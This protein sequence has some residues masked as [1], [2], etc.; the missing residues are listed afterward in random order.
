MR[1]RSRYWLAGAALLIA[2]GTALAQKVVDRV[3]A[4]VEDGII[5]QSDLD[6]LRRYQILTDEKAESDEQL[7]NRLIDQWVVRGEADTSHFP[8]PTDAEVDR[9]MDRLQRSYGSK[10]EFETKVKDAGL[11]EA[12]VRKMVTSQ[13]Y[14]SNYL[15]SRFRPSVQVDQKQIEDFYENRVVPRAK[16]RGT[17][18]PPLSSARD[19]IQEALV[20][21]GINE[22]AD[23][24]LKETR[25]RLQVDILTRSGEQ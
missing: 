1:G 12:E 4:R 16:A 21:R 5:L 22:Q 24:W 8:K 6:E 15:D 13:L 7:M 17:P 9:A 20:Q 3:I 25:T 23:R 19:Y 2:A 11:D 10:E 18:P 14:L